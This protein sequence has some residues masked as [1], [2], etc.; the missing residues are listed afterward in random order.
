MP[1]LR[2]SWPPLAYLALSLLMTWPLALHLGDGLPGLG[3][4]LLQAWTIAWNAQALASETM[5]WDAPIFHPYPDALAFTDNHLLLS[6]ATAPLTWATGEPL[7]A[8]NL[9]LLLSFAFSGWATYLLA[10]DTLPKAAGPW[11]P[12][13]AGAAFAFCAYRFAHLTQLNLLQ[14]AWMVF[15]LVFLRRLLRPRKAGGGRVGDAL[16][17]GL[18]AG[19]QAI[20]ALYYAFFTAALL[21]GYTLLW[22]AGGVWARLRAGVPLPWRQAALVALAGGLGTTLALPFTLPYTRVFGSL[23]IVRSARELDGWSA[24]LRA[25]VSVTQGNLLY[26]RLGE[27]VV[28]AGEMVLFPGLL[29][30]ALAL[31]GAGMILNAALRG[32]SRRR[33]G[34][35]FGAEP[36]RARGAAQGIR[37]AALAP[38]D[39]AFWPIVAGAAFLLSLGTGLRLVRFGEPLPLPLPY[40]LLYAY[41]PGFGALRVPARWGLLV[42]LALAV[43]AAVA[44]AALLA[45][46]RPRWRAALG[47]AA[48]AVV[49]AEQA[50][51]PIGLPA[52][53]S[54]TAAPP[55]YA[56]LAEPEQAALGPVLELPVAAVPRGE[57]LERITLRQWRGRLHW[58]PLVASY[59]GLIPF[60]TSDLLRRAEDLPDEEHLS[61]LRLA[62]VGALVVH[63]DELDQ[64]AGAA[65]LAGLDASPQAERRAEVGAAVVYSLPPDPRLAEAEAAA[66]PGGSVLVSGDERAPG[67]AA[68]AIVRRLRAAGREL[69]GPARPRYYAALGQPRPGQ[70]FD[71]GLLADAEDPRASG[72]S[73]AGL[74]WRGDGLALYRRDPALLTSLGLAEVVPGQFH[75]RHPSGLGFGLGPRGPRAGE[76]ELP[77]RAPDGARFELDVAALEPVELNLGGERVTIPPGLSTIGLSLAPGLTALVEGPEGRL[78]LLRLRALDTPPAPPS[79]LPNTGLALGAEAAL[80]G[81]E[82]VVRARGA[83]AAGL[84]LDIKGASAYDDRPVNLLAG[85]Q[86]LPAG[87]GELVFA[88]DPLRPRAPWLSGSAE[89]LDGRYIAYLRDAGAP[90]GPG[91]PVAQFHIRGGQLVDFEAVPLPLA[92]VW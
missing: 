3:D 67:V 18:F 9:L 92:A 20:T 31:G 16:R 8:H 1:A 50:A 21:G 12:F 87:G 59:S 27:R 10:R 81:T 61:F 30:A 72:F 90:D 65:L 57:E 73:P 85:A 52:G 2:S 83:G 49:L 89:P 68:L 39:A 64:E 26:A 56:W 15:A 45:R 33:A 84:L 74:V 71:A 44:L 54:I 14:T 22:A 86:P 5:V 42:T 69:Y 7:L 4:A 82:L 17:C 55:V 60:G 79:V 47:A 76:V 19:L 51:P 37:A 6:A 70:V 46:L 28:D 62:G 48:L 66:G 29:V 58:R 32:F 13:V 80:E 43:L 63:T 40:S 53:P 25:Y 78:A 24:P 11:P 35:T 23:S 88:V 38:L 91:A 41:V 77:I 75:P 36:Q 34:Q